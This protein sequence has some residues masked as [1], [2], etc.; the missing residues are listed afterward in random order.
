M[1]PFRHKKINQN[2]GLAGY[3]CPRCK[4]THIGVPNIQDSSHADYIKVW[5]GHR[6]VT[7]RCLDCGLDFYNPEPPEGITEDNIIAGGI[8]DEE[9]LQSA[10]DKLKQQA[11]D[12]D[13]R[14]CR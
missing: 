12:E 1:W 8:I 11:E 14:R 3:Q 5:K 4:S 7:V 13:D 10:E 2:P 9:E 6:Y